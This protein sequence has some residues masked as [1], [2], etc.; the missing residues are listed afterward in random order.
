MNKYDRYHKR[1]RE[2]A[3]S[4]LGGRCWYCFSKYDLEIDHIESDGWKERRNGHSRSHVM[5]AAKGDT[6][7]LQLLCHGCH[8]RKTVMY[9]WVKANRELKEME[10]RYEFMVGGD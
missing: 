1:I 4:N 2:Q 10:K 7:G 6:E 9:N 8:V 5:R 3:L